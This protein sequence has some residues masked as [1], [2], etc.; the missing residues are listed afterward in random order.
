VL[1]WESREFT[2]KMVYV[3]YHIRCPE[4]KSTSTLVVQESVPIIFECNW[5]E[6]NI[7]V[8]G[9]ILYTVSREAVKRIVKKFKYKTCGK[10][11]NF[12]ASGE[13]K[14]SITNSKIKELHKT[15]TK[16]DT[17]EDILKRI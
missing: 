17:V 16:Y 3:E 2:E 14:Y 11:V 5:C 4:C 6:R 8:Q 12:K 15:L 7:V 10:V 9:N 1:L 13:P